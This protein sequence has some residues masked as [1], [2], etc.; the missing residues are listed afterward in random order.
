MGDE[1]EPWRDR[2][3]ALPL[4]G[5]EKGK[6]FVHIKKDDDMKALLAD[7]NTD[8]ETCVSAVRELLR[9]ARS[10]PAAAPAAGADAG[11]NPKHAKKGT[12]AV[13]ATG[14][15]IPDW[16]HLQHQRQ[17]RGAGL[18]QRHVGSRAGVHD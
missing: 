13:L 14:N 1:R 7:Q 11:A 10:P 9:I 18:R 8:L 15:I 6:A 4:T 3:N 2:L 5:D 16:Q 12:E 17:Q